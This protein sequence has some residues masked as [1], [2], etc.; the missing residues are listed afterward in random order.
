MLQISF[1][2][3]IADAAPSDLSK[4]AATLRDAADKVQK[5][6]EQ[7]NW[8]EDFMKGPKS[9]EKNTA[10]STASSKLVTAIGKQCVPSAGGAPTDS[11]P[12]TP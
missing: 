7:T 1:L 9:L 8:S 6:G 3:A 11:A 2:R 5:E 10:Y 4:E 12:A